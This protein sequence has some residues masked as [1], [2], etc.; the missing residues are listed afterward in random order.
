MEDETWTEYFKTKYN[1]WYDILNRVTRPE[2]EN[3][4]GDKYFLR[5]WARL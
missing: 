1:E 5:V 4:L 2:Y 3:E